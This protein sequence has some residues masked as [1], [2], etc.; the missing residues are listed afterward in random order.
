[1]ER[2]S[3]LE[4]KVP[5]EAGTL[6]AR[7]WRDGK[8]VSTKV[9]T[10]DDPVTIVLTPDRQSI[11]ADGE[12][13]CVVNVTALDGHGR[14]VP[15]ADNLIRF[16]VNGGGRIIGVGNGNPSS[17]EPDK[18]LDGNYQRKLFNGKC[19]VIVQAGR[20]ASGIELQASSD[21]LK[22]AKVIIKA[23]ESPARPSVEQ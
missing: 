11:H 4:W 13:V 21:G 9:E 17:H 18:Y 10:T 20:E 1:M 3:H 12:D 6:E 23:E 15:V 2:N 16:E 7:G 5:Y 19:Q 8:K 22:L 14:E